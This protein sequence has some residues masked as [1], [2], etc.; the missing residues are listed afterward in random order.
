MHVKKSVPGRPPVIKFTGRNYES[1]SFVQ[2][3]THAIN[4]EIM[5]RPQSPLLCHTN[6]GLS[7]KSFRH[8]VD[9]NEIDSYLY[10]FSKRRKIDARG[11]NIKKG[12]FVGQVLVAIPQLG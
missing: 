5:T 2:S 12:Q 8:I 6:N 1:F 4:N 11:N 9:K 3:Q 10:D 7:D